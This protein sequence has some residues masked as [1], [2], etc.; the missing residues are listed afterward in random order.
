[1]GK[2]VYIDII[3]FFVKTF[4]MNL[5]IYYSFNKIIIRNKFVLNNKKDTM[6]F[7]I[8]NLC[9]SMIY[10]YLDY[11][12]D[13]ATITL[14][15]Y[16]LLAIFLAIITKNKLGYSFV[17][18]TISYAI[19]N[20][21]LL[22]STIVNFLPYYYIYKFNFYLNT[23]SVLLV[24]V[25][26]TY[27]FFKWKRLGKSFIFLNNKLNNDITDVIVSIISIIIML[28]GTFIGT[29]YQVSN[30]VGYDVFAIFL[31]LA[32]TLVV[33]IHKTLTMHY[34]QTQLLKTM[35]EYKNEIK[36][37]DDKI[38]K[39]SKEKYNTSKIR[40]E[41]YNRQKALE[42]LVKSNFVK[43]E[44]IQENI[45]QNVLDM[46]NSLTSEYSA[47]CERI[48]EL[49]ELTKTDIPEIDNMFKYMQSECA[50]NNITFKLVIKGNIHALVNNIIPKS[51]L[52]TLIG[53]HIRDA[54]NAINN[55]DI[56]NK[57]I[58][59]VL[60]INNDAYEL[61]IYDTGKEFEIDTLLKLGLEATT[62]CSDKGGTGIGF[63]T[64][65][66]TMS[67]TKAS[68][69]I[70]EMSPTESEYYTKSVAIRFDDKQEYMIRSYRANLIKSKATD[71]RIIIEE[72]IE[73]NE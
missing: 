52:E 13:S 38:E 31:L 11:K 21:A 69:I 37:K 34:K 39:L 35:E 1:M 46:I 54:I 58:L 7:T 50:N 42:L 48:K 51:R 63:M 49:D 33:M 53:D 23:I 56:V 57:E 18:T 43:D 55:K 60:G 62:T 68:L 59:V 6:I 2:V 12:F 61:V 3:T 70:T 14:L 19:S 10:V 45:N 9:L 26:L 24:Q 4:I 5:C 22:C 72:L 17:I 29:L 41:F 8:F 65:F 47:E 30:Y 44:N 27:A 28:V 73:E 32:I 40:H 67:M 36:E 16:I 66:E 20:V 25:I 64:T 71:N 15:T